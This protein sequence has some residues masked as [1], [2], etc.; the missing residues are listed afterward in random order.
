MERESSGRPKALRARRRSASLC[1]NASGSWNPRIATYAAVHGPI[2]GIAS[3]RV[4]PSAGSEPASMWTSPLASRAARVCNAS[5]R[6]TGPAMV[7]GSASARTAGVGTDVSPFRAAAPVGYRTL[8]RDALSESAPPAARPA[9][10][11]LRAGQAPRHRRTPA[12]AAPARSD[13]AADH[14][15]AAE[16]LGDGH[17]VGVE[18][19]QA[20]AA[21]YRR[22]EVAKVEMENTMDGSRFGVSSTIPM[23]W[24]RVSARR[25]VPSLTSSRLGT[26][27]IS[28]NRNNAAPS[29]GS[30][31][32][33]EVRRFPVS[34]GWHPST[35]RLH[36]SSGSAS[37][38]GSSRR[39]P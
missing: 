38:L 37:R 31:S 23:P 25:Y 12:L 33:G 35:E 9:D 39:R 4:S 27:R 17:R 24:A 13:E 7:L 16:R 11:A 30:G 6:R 36:P 1:G 22:G 20:P 28:R 29:N 18:V 10:R 2:P 19:E 34:G 32:S 14:L 8:G 15:V 3:S 21:C 5:R 26:A